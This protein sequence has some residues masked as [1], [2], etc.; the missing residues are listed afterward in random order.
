MS[1]QKRAK[2]W[3]FGDFE[4]PPDWKEE[5]K[6]KIVMIDRFLVPNYPPVQIFSEKYDKMSQGT[7]WV[8]FVPI[9]I[10]EL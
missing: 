3:R 6:S 8:F 4:V 7:L 5:V 9:Y 2:K 10:N 1:G